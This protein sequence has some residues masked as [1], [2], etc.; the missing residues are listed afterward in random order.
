M[1]EK[2][3]DVVD[4][5]WKS[6]LLPKSSFLG[7]LIDNTN[8]PITETENT[9]EGIYLK[10]VVLDQLLINLV[11]NIFNRRK[12]RDEVSGVINSEKRS[13]LITKLF[14]VRSLVIFPKTL[15]SKK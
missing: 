3:Y 1:R 15:T 14:S 10:V 11:W 13:E 6:E 8:S 4:N 2:V 5:E 7:S 12:L 9:N